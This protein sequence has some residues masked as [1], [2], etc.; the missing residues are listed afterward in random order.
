MWAQSNKNTMVLK[1]I[2]DYGCSLENDSLHIT[3]GTEENMQMVCESSV[4]Y[5]KASNVS[6]VAKT[7]VAVE[8]NLYYFSIIY[9]SRGKVG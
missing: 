9:Y 4:C 7:Y 3:W 6:L 2:T 5:S 8:K 1:P